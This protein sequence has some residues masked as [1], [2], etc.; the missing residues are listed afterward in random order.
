MYSFKCMYSYPAG[1]SGLRSSILHESS[2]A[3][4]EN[5]NVHTKYLVNASSKASD[6]TAHLSKIVLDLSTCNCLIL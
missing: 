6:R 2:S 1:I 4:I 5:H 3:L